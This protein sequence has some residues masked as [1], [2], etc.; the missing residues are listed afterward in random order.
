[1]STT[2]PAGT[3]TV[4]V[5]A[6]TRQ[7]LRT[8]VLAASFGNLVEWFDFT[9]YG[10]LA[11]TIAVHFFTAEGAAE[12]ST[13][14]LLA[15]AT[16]G[17]GFLARP[18][19]GLL[20]GLY[21]DRRG[22]KPALLLS[23]GL[24]G[25]S[26]FAVALLPDQSSIGLAAPLLLVLLR[27]LQGVAAGGEWGG[28]ASFLVEWAPTRRRG[29]FGSVHTATIFVGTLTGSL[30]IAAL[31]AGL[32]A[33]AMGDW[34]WRIPFA[35]GGVL[36]LIAIPVRLRAEETPVFRAEA[37]H[38]ADAAA[39]ASTTGTTTAGTTTAGTLAAERPGVAASM[40]TTRRALL[41][42]L[43]FTFC[44]VG[45]QS[46]AVY[47]YTSYF[48][49]FAQRYT[50][51]GGEPVGADAALFSNALASV[52]VI[53]VVVASGTLSDRVGRKP[54]M[55]LSCF[56]VL[57]LSYPLIWLASTADSLAVTVAVQCALA[58]SVAVFLGCLPVVLVELFPAR[59]RVAGLSTSYNISSAVFG[60]FAPLIA[61]GLVD[62]T[63]FPP[64]ASLWAVT[65]AV[66]S[67]VAV[68]FFRETRGVD[69]A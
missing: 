6:P 12:S 24:M 25:A 19:G 32:G 66:V 29:L 63:G 22:R 49:T 60:G 34:G 47:T 5:G 14:V 17:V 23:I 69:L 10:L 68:L 41:R 39:G 7:Q 58:A 1:M 2:P 13:P 62:V 40:P 43:G 15:F 33:D 28:A 67:T 53:A 54:G 50:T 57:T 35:I 11:T 9:T 8:T 27:L 59:V 42:R 26:T 64:N 36:A 4:E 65:A 56:L 51:N 30:T 38:A 55:V 61:S 52:V 21:G 16:F 46:A 18:L 3:G 45:M 31:T 37:A 44:L 48:P 20:I